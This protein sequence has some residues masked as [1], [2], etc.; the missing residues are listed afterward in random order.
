MNDVLLR[1]RVRELVKAGLVPCDEPHKVW[2]GRGS[3]THCVACGQPITPGEVEYEVELASAVFRV[4]RT[5][6]TV[7]REECESLPV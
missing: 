3:G 1:A 2:A 5:C 6:F 7:W 4:H